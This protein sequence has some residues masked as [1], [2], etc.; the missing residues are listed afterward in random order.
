MK[1]IKVQIWM[2]KKIITVSISIN[3]KNCISRKK[4]LTH[5]HLV[6]IEKKLKH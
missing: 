5:T 4:L 3:E 1:K 6:M 2:R